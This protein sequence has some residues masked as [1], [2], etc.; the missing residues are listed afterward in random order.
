MISVVASRTPPFYAGTALN[1]TC[2][3]PL[4]AAVDLPVVRR[5]QWIINDVPLDTPVSSDR[6]VFSER[7]IVFN[8]LNFSDVATYKCNV[9]FIN[10]FFDNSDNQELD[11]NIEA[12]PQPEVEITAPPTVIAGS[13]LTLECSVTVVPHL[14]STPRVELSGPGDVVLATG[15]NLTLTHTLDPVLVSSAGQQYVCKTELEIESLGVLQTSQSTYTITVQIPRPTVT[16]AVD[17]PDV[18]VIHS[19]VVLTCMAILDPHVDSLASVTIVWV[20]PRPFSGGHYSVNESGFGLN[21]NSSLTISDVAKEDEGE[22]ACTVRVFGGRN[23]LGTVVTESTSISNVLVPRPTVTLSA[24][25]PGTLNPS[26][27]VTLTCEATLDSQVEEIEDLAISLTWGGPRVISDDDDS[28]FSIIESAHTSNLMILSV[29]NGDEGEYMCT[30]VVSRGGNVLSAPVTEHIYISV[31]AP[32]PPEVKITAPLV[33][34]DGSAV[35]LEC[36]MT[37]VPHDHITTTSFLGLF[38]PKEVVLA[39]STNFTLT[40]TLDPV[41][42][43][44]A[45]PYFCKAVLEIE[46]LDMPLESQSLIHPL[47]VKVPFPTLTV[48]ASPPGIINIGSSVTLKCECIWNARTPVSLSW[49]TPIRSPSSYTNITESGNRLK[50]VSNTTISNVEKRDEGEYSCTVTPDDDLMPY[51]IVPTVTRSISLRVFGEGNIL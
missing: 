27:S 43:V 38:G 35:T 9:E 18:L 50:F 40:H 14:T 11:L 29:D 23:V 6:V 15:T 47:T 25:P 5:I 33:V 46:G 36:S 8:P 13:K 20:G 4:N 45:G 37:G 24:N 17:P 44:D 7:N 30:V 32:L 10:R 34:M 3:I 2:N 21:Y 42:A 26:S 49:D 16:T 31:L 22:Y 28:K 1:L 41:L 12:L 48:T 51:V 19:P 39:N